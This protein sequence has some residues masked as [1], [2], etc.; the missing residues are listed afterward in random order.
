[1]KHTQ[2]EWKAVI[3]MNNPM[4]MNNEIW[5]ESINNPHKAIAVLYSGA[6]DINCDNAKANAKLIAAAPELL[7]FVQEMANRYANSEWIAAEANK[8]IAKATT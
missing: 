4:K 1:M 8:L 3:D 7:A 2:G 5:I 6:N